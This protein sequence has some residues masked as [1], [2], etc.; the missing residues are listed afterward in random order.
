M[1][2]SLLCSLL[3]FKSLCFGHGVWRL[4]SNVGALDTG[5][6][7]ASILTCTDFTCANGILVLVGVLHGCGA[8]ATNCTS[9]CSRH[10][11]RAQVARLGVDWLNVQFVVAQVIFGVV[12]HLSSLFSVHEGR[13]Q[14]SR[15]D[16]CVVNKVQ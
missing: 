13:L 3:L 6:G 1:L 10:C 8:G 14:I 11:S 15:N 7:V 4:A 5:L 9:R 12:E 2:R 16:W